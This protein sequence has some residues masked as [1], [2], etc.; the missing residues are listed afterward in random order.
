[1]YF[2]SMGATFYD[3]TS[4][5][6][7]ISGKTSPED[8]LDC[9]GINSAACFFTG[10]EFMAMLCSNTSENSRMN[11]TKMAINKANAQ[12]E[13]E[14]RLR[15]ELRAKRNRGKDR[16]FGRHDTEGKNEEE[17]DAMGIRNVRTVGEKAVQMLEFR[18]TAFLGNIDMMRIRSM[19]FL[20]EDISTPDSSSNEGACKLQAAGGTTSEGA[21]ALSHSSLLQGVLHITNTV[22][23][24]SNNGSPEARRIQGILCVLWRR[25]KNLETIFKL[26]DINVPS[27]A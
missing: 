10:V 22:G 4:K 3:H 5:Q 20:L 7:V 9:P 27:S 23:V 18:V 21:I 24:T 19:L 8:A 26:F 15:K 14:E 25:T 6:V 2:R 13:E 17:A 12:K 16:A 1:M 11:S